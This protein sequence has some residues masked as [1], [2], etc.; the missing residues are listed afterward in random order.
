MPWPEPILRKPPSTRRAVM[1]NIVMMHFSIMAI[2]YGVFTRQSVMANCVSET[3]A[4]V[5]VG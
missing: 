4:M 2:G 5:G 3:E 1:A